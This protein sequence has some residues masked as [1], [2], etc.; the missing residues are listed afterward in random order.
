MIIAFHTYGL[1]IGISLV[2]ALGL[3]ERKLKKFNYSE[4]SLLKISLMALVFSIV[5]ARVWHVITDFYLYKH[6]LIEIFYIWNGG[7]SILGGVLGS[8]VGI[9]F[10]TLI[11]KE[12]KEIKLMVMLDSMVFALPFAQVL[13]RLGNYVNQELYGIPTNFFMKISIDEQHRLPGF[14][15]EKF[16]HPL[17]FYE[18]IMMFIFGNIIYY[19]DSKKKLSR[20]G[21][22]KLFL[23]YILYYS[24]V[25]FLLDFI[26][27]DKAM[28]MDTFF[29]I[30]Q[31]FLLLLIVTLLIR[32]KYLKF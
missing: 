22:G 3:I 26:R 20:I 10:A 24:V 19:L 29:S 32:K 8:V 5:F 18:M 13:G 17:F 11:F 7:L 9:K 14:E 15:N 28:F 6:S 23:V 16:Y 30:N 21:S 2:I 25:R 27:L 12:C 4:S 31:I 1:I